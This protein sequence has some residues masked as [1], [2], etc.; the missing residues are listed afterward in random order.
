VAKKKPKTDPY[1]TQAGQLAL[2]RYGPQV[3]HAY[4][5]AQQAVQPA[6]AQGGGVEAQALQ[7]RLGE[8]A[9]LATSQ[10]AAR[11]VSAIEGEGAARAQ[12]IRDFGSDRDKIAQ[13]AL[14]LSREQGAF[15]AS[16][17]TDLIGADA[18]ARADAKK[19]QATL[20]QQ[21]RNS[22]RSAGIDPDTGQPIPGG[23]LDPK[24]KGKGGGGPDWAPQEA[25]TKARS[26]ISTALTAAQQLKKAGVS[27]KDAAQALLQGADEKSVELYDPTTGKAQIWQDGEPGNKDGSKTGQKKTTVLQGGLPKIDDQLYLSAA[28]DMA[29]DNH[30]SRRNQKLLHDNLIKIKP[31][32][33]TTY[34]D[35]L[36]ELDKATKK[37]RSPHPGTN[38]TPGANG[39]MRPT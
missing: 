13:R 15:T 37:M 3:T 2:T 36:R 21:E 39:Q 5:A 8:G 4:T 7:A 25:Q 34:Q 12:A 28:L 33:V 24:A 31:L 20:D 6:F 10:L 27:R 26:T 14:D 11:K 1:A 16:T 32:G 23:K 9:A 17:I 38:K 35:W 22:L 29:Y 19:Q 30:L 18:S